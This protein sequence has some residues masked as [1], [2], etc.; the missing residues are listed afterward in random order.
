VVVVLSASRRAVA[1]HPATSNAAPNQQ[2]PNNTN[3]LRG[4]RRFPRFPQKQLVS[5]R[6]PRYM[7][8][9]PR[10]E[11]RPNRRNATPR[12]RRLRAEET[13]R[14]SGGLAAIDGPLR[15]HQDN[16]RHGPPAYR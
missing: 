7:Q 3:V 14:H 13:D 2:A 9:Q 12:S 10:M 6:E 16:R 8:T 1:A 15:R 5:L 11:G 4:T